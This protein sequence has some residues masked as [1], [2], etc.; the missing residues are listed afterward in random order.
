MSGFVT[1]KRFAELLSCSTGHISN[2]KR[3]GRLVLNAEGLV[4]VEASKARIQSTAGADER[5][6]VVP[7]PASDHRERQQ[8]LQ[9]D[10]LEMEVA[11]KR[12]ELLR[13]DQVRATVVTA[14]T[15]LRTALEALP[16]QVAPRL[17]AISDEGEVRNIL[18]A[19]IEVLLAEA[20]HHFGKLAG[21][22]A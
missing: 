8:R 12:G 14:A 1:Q 17:A 7:P 11:E 2:L 10:L 18:A 6:G 15:G 9:A 4:D 3:A 21:E 20:A 13:A 5:L 16:Y 19:E 22:V